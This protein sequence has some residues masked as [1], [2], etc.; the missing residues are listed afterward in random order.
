MKANATEVHSA[1]MNTR[2]LNE[3]INETGDL[4]GFIGRR[5]TLHN[6]IL[7]QE[8]CIVCLKLLFIHN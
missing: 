1:A 4:K 7:E 6:N 5:N 8:K 2:E 3:N